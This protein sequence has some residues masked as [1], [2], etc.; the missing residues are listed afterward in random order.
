[1]TSSKLA[2]IRKPFITQNLRFLHKVGLI[3]TVENIDSVVEGDRKTSTV[4]WDVTPCSPVEVYRRFDRMLANFCQTTCCHIPEDSTLHRHC[5]ENFIF[6]T[7]L[8]TIMDDEEVKSEIRRPCSVRR[9]HP[10]SPLERL[11][12]TA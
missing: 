5:C 12:N 4:S 2:Y 6:N 7:D 8:K 3:Q 10:S 1:M 9:N 11:G